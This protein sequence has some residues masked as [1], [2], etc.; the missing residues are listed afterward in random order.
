LIVHG[1]RPQAVEA[2]G[3]L[4][5]FLR[6]A[7][8]RTRTLKEEGVPADEETDEATFPDG[9]DLV[10][11][12]GGDGTMLRAAK[13]AAAADAPLLGV[14]VGRVGFLTQ[15]EPEGSK[16][17]LE[18]LLGGDLRVEERTAL[19]ATPSRAP[20]SEPEWALNEVIVSKEHRHQ[21]VHVAVRIGGT[22]V[23]TYS[24]DGVIVATP[25]G[26]TAYAFSA[27]GPIVS[28]EVHAMLLTPVAPHMVFD[29]SI[30]VGP[31]E[32]VA[33]EILPDE[34][35]LLSADGRPG[36]PLPVGASVV[37][38]PAPRPARLVHNGDGPTFFPLLRAKFSLPGSPT[39]SPEAP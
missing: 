26:S 9:L 6:G 36:L 2:A 37:V 28:P 39:P 32:E 21:L 25:T 17:L 34:P 5:R 23:T 11:S 24:G 38:R 10:V 16:A 4:A 14:K 19:A 12:V 29:R 8:V 30:V 1:G 31:D 35:G 33:L 7:G 20:W 22:Y 18:R 3:E 13:V 15:A 27:G